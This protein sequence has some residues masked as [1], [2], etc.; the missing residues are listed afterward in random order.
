MTLGMVCI[1]LEMY[2]NM[3]RILFLCEGTKNVAKA[4]KNIAQ[5]AAKWEGTKWF[6]DLSDKC[7]YMYIY[8]YLLS[9]QLQVL[10]LPLHRQ[11]H[12]DPH[13]LGHEELWW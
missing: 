5:G 10:C 12:Q 1:T 3:M 9:E 8:M 7:M 4:M 11:E 2:L 6:R 13:V